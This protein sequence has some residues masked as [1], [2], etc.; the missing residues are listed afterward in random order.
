MHCVDDWEE[1][2]ALKWGEH[3]ADTKFGIN[4]FTATHLAATY[5]KVESIFNKYNLARCSSLWKMN[6][7]G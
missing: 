1:D 4:D 3:V 7:I 5:D 2:M 6:V